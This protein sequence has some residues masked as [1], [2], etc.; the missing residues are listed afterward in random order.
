MLGIN[1]QPIKFILLE[2]DKTQKT[3]SQVVCLKPALRQMIA[4]NFTILAWSPDDTKI[5]YVASQ[6]ADLPLIIKPRLLAV[7]TLY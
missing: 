5:L 4:D 1:K 6:S 3:Q 2:P 7:D